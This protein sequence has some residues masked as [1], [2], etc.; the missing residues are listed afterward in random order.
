MELGE[1]E[2]KEC[3]V[4]F[5]YLRKMDHRIM[6]W[7]MGIVKRKILRGEARDPAPNDRGFEIYLS[8]EHAIFV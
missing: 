4:N 6:Q 1:G 7:H 3:N 8:N 5:L 2:V